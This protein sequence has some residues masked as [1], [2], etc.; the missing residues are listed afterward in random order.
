MVI[1]QDTNYAYKLKYI[2]KPCFDDIRNLAVK[3]MREITSATSR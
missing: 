3:F 2:S 1:E